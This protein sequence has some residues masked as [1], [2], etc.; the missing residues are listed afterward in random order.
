MNVFTFNKINKKK[1]SKI[2]KI[3][4]DTL[5]PGNLLLLEGPL[6]AGKTFFTTELCKYLGVK[7]VV[8]SP[9]YVLLNEYSGKFNILH[10]DLY[11]LQYPE[12][13]FEIGMFDNMLEHITIIEWPQLIESYI[14]SDFI[15][16]NINFSENNNQE[17][18]YRDLEIQGNKKIKKLGEL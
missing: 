9:S 11:R 6:G 1:I 8:N 10:Y 13:A 5:E 7:T 16:I 14:K 17:I 12:E 4:A 2:A 18:L 15:K 3:I